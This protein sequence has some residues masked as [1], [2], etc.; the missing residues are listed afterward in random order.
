MGE[1]L[2]MSNKNPVEVQES[3]YKLP[4][5]WF[6]DERLIEFKR[7]EKRRIIF[8]MIDQYSN[9][10]IQN[11]LDVG[12]GDGRW[13]SEINDYLKT[14]SIGIDFSKRAIEFAKLISPD[15]EFKMHEGQDLPFPEN[16]FDLCTTIEVIEHV[17]DNFEIKFLKECARVLKPQGLLILTTPSE[18]LRLTEHHYRHYTVKRLKELINANGFELLSIRGQSLPCYGYTRKI[19]KVMSRNSIIW[20][21]WKYTHKE[22]VPDKAL[23]LFIA[24]RT[25]K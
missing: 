18:K 19:R 14:N 20:K 10:S 3:Y 11:F 7:I 8:E 25:I 1:K 12:C 13:T 6:P 23:N 9:D 21:L 2:K 22:V 15:I 17:E 5:H 24:A 16:T 4:Y